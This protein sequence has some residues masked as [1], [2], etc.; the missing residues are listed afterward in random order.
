MSKIVF[1]FRLDD[2]FG[3]LLWRRRVLLEIKT[4][5]GQ[6]SSR[7]TPLMYSSCFHKE[8]NWKIVNAQIKYSI[9]I[10]TS[11]LN[12]LPWPQDSKR[13]LWSPSQ[14]ATYPPLYHTQ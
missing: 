8:K 9:I 11:L 13:I 12:K 2:L 14:A 6:C 4:I 5:L 7:R 1:F 3:Y 10:I